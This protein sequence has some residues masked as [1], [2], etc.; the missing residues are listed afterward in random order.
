MTQP[1][2]GSSLLFG[3]LAESGQI[4]LRKNGSYRM[5]LEGVD[6]ID[7]FTDRPNRV[8]GTWKPQKLL[9]KW[10]KYFAS[11]E[12]NAQATVEVGKQ[13]ELF[14]FEMSKPRIKSGKM[15]FNIKSLSDSSED[16]VTGL[17]G[18]G[19]DKVSVFIDNALEDS[20]LPSC[21][22]NCYEAK[23]SGIDLS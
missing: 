5:V 4:K 2:A 15:M 23:L 21:F 22:P 19:M 10:D 16:K 13:K 14:T 1:P 17:M 8:E 3:A 6:E 20:G 12:P 18:K 9:R 11:S 7:W